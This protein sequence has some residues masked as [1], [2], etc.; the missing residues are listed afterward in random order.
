[1]KKKG[2][3]VC[4]LLVIVFLSVGFISASWYS[5]PPGINTQ[6]ISSD[7]DGSYT[8]KKVWNSLTS[9]DADST[10]SSAHYSESFKLDEDTHLLFGARSTDYTST[11][12]STRKNLETQNYETTTTTYSEGY[13]G[14][15]SNDGSCFI[16][17]SSSS[18]EDSVSSTYSNCGVYPN[19]WFFNSNLN[20]VIPLYY[21]SPGENVPWCD[22]TYLDNCIQF[23]ETDTCDGSTNKVNIK[24]NLKLDY[25]TDNSDEESSGYTQKSLNSFNGEFIAI[26]FWNLGCAEFYQADSGFYCGVRVD[27]YYGQDC[28]DTT[29]N[30]DGRIYSTDADGNNQDL[31]T[32]KFTKYKTLLDSDN[33][34]FYDIYQFKPSI[35]A[36][37]FSRIVKAAK[38]A[39][40]DVYCKA[41]DAVGYLRRSE[42]NFYVEQSQGNFGSSCNY[43][44]RN[45]KTIP[46]KTVN[47]DGSVDITC[48]YDVG[49]TLTNGNYN[50]EFI[51]REGSEEVASQSKSIVV[52]WFT[53]LFNDFSNYHSTAKFTGKLNTTTGLLRC[54]A[55]IV[56]TDKPQSKENSCAVSNWLYDIDQDGYITYFQNK[57]IADVQKQIKSAPDF[58]GIIVDQGDLPFPFDKLDCSD[59]IYGNDKIKINENYQ[60]VCP[61]NPEDWFNLREEVNKKITQAK[62]N[63]KSDGTG[64]VSRMPIVTDHVAK[65]DICYYDENNDGI[66][67]YS[68]CSYCRNPEM[69]EIADN[70]DNDCQGSCQANPQAKCNIYTTSETSPKYDNGS[71]VGDG[72]NNFECDGEQSSY[73]GSDNFCQMVDDN[74]ILDNSGYRCGGY[75]RIVKHMNY[76]TKSADIERDLGNVPA[77]VAYNKKDCTKQIGD[78]YTQYAFM[79]GGIP[80]FVFNSPIFISGKNL[81][82]K[83]IYEY[84]HLF[85]PTQLLS[86]T[87]DSITHT[88]VADTLIVLPAKEVNGKTRNTLDLPEQFIDSMWGE[89]DFKQEGE[90]ESNFDKFFGIL[91]KDKILEKGSSDWNWQLACVPKDKCADNSDND[92]PKSLYGALPYGLYTRPATFE[93]TNVNGE[94]NEFAGKEDMNIPFTD[95]DDPSCKFK[96]DA[97]T[98]INLE[99]INNFL[100]SNSDLKFAADM[101]R[102]IP[103]SEDINGKSKTY[104]LDVD[105]DGFCVCQP[106]DSKEPT[107]L[108]C[109][110]QFIDCNDAPSE[111]SQYI[112]DGGKRILMGPAY[113]WGDWVQ[114][115]K[116]WQLSGVGA[117]QP[118]GAWNIHP[119]SPVTSISCNFGKFDLNC[120]KNGLEGYNYISLVNGATPFDDDP[121]TGVERLD[122]SSGIRTTNT[123]FMCYSTSFIEKFAGEAKERAIVKV[124]Q[125]G[126]M[127]LLMFVPGLNALPTAVQAGILI[128][129]VTSTALETGDCIKSIKEG[130][131]DASVIWDKCLTLASHASGFVVV[132]GK[133]GVDKIK[134][135]FGNTNKPAKLNNVPF[136]RGELGSEIVNP[137]KKPTT[138]VIPTTGCFLENTSIM[139]EDGSL[140]DIQ[141]IEVGDRVMAFDIENNQAVNSSVTAF[142]IRNET[143][144]RIIEY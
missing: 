108:S 17:H 52:N 142:F 50:V 16:E 59:W 7:M 62:E 93:F 24:R 18:G 64:S 90:S 101:Y 87:L 122:T 119:F 124:K 125:E 58:S 99:T 21:L 73:G 65:E 79:P 12:S 107:K 74:A 136:T 5:V 60:K 138:P 117:G 63:F 86:C 6:I 20:Q 97:M 37:S 36:T 45:I 83:Y 68:Q 115:D 132:G 77:I 11:D 3:V 139:M 128:Y 2:A 110:K 106:F 51:L 81:Q 14:Q 84:T 26:N 35:D 114:I 98:S 34:Y 118:L 76:I 47:S 80:N 137:I 27:N 30:I 89:L 44:G 72:A 95:M 15:Y 28:R 112:L 9:Q 8:E 53:D 23:S 127:M 92:G 113:G 105:Q 4:F 41:I 135:K 104:C 42:G 129:G 70:I 31:A 120:N 61:T 85:N 140:K 1:M 43:C 116:S 48:D 133:I 29:L 100:G 102:E 39:G 33:N 126:P 78:E 69:P 22:E 111:D 91:K 121:S 19:Y 25:F 94:T 71:F 38:D 141:N 103:Y 57:S 88:A 46:T 82:G 96:N 32:G 109:S 10:I 130:T 144:Y 66:P 49:F 56:N 55:K 40:G 67:D 123:D 54:E 143:K 13:R 134:V 131:E 75:N